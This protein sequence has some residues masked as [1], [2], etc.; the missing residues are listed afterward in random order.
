MGDVIKNNFLLETLKKKT[1]S[2]LIDELKFD[3]EYFETEKE[4][5]YFS[6]DKNIIVGFLN[7]KC[8]VAKRNGKNNEYEIICDNLTFLRMKNLVKRFCVAVVMAVENRLAS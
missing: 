4:Y 2:F 1:H 7:R 8:Y 3:Y 6:K 5:I